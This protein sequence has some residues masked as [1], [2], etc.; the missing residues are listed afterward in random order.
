MKSGKE[1]EQILLA[2][3][4]YLEKLLATAIKQNERL[5]EVQQHKI[6]VQRHGNGYQYYIRSGEKDTSGK[7]LKK[8]Q[9]AFIKQTLQKEYLHKCIKL[10]QGELS[11][12]NLYLLKNSPTQLESYY[13]NMNEGRKIIIDPIEIDTEE[14]VRK[15]LSVQYRGKEFTVD[16]P[17]YYT[18]KMERVRS[19]SEIIIA[20]TLNKYQI[21]YRY[22]YPISLNSIGKVYPDFTV[23]NVRKRKEVYWEHFGLVDDYDY[24]EKAMRK[25]TA[26]EKSDI[27]PGDKLI[28]TQESIAQ[29]LSVKDIERKIEKY[30]L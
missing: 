25:M 21:P 3:R 2:R 29:P 15:W 17:E 27:F 20:N 28:I 24:R 19:K 14:Y 30:L 10:I 8:D 26:Y 9:I 12:L 18:D 16:A 7:Y 23:L 11:S 1:T 13:K 4:E 22:E 5:P 6:R